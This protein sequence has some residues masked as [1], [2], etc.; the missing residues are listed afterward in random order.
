MIGLLQEVLGIMNGIMDQQSTSQDEDAVLRDLTELVVI[1]L[2]E[3]EDFLPLADL[4]E[5]YVD[6]VE[7][8]EEVTGIEELGVHSGGLGG[9]AD[10]D[11]RKTKRSHQKDDSV[12]VLED[13]D[14]VHAGELRESTYR[15]VSIVRQ[16]IPEKR[17]VKEVKID[18]V[19]RTPGRDGNAMKD[20]PILS[21]PH[22]KK[23]K[24]KKPPPPFRDS[25][26]DLTIPNRS[27]DRRMNSVKTL[28]WI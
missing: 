13:E 5:E 18:A 6:E 19:P 23:A 15:E 25:A 1:M 28:G 3:A 21:T 24:L 14:N 10:W 22:P 27:T 2:Q 12:V 4:E 17:E 26:L 11:G 8:A 20:V 7:L 16:Q 9:N